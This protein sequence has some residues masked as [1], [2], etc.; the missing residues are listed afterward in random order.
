MYISGDIPATCVQEMPVLALGISSKAG[1]ESAF[2][3]GEEKP[4]CGRDLGPA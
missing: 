4:E 2:A 3:G 1:R